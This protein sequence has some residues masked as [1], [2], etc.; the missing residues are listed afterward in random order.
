MQGKGLITLVAVVLGL[1]CLNELL[2]TWYASKIENQATQIAG[3]D[4]VKYQKEM[5]RLSKDTLNLGFTKLYYSRAKEREMKLG[6]DLKGGI[7]ALLE[8]NQRDLINDLTN[9]STNPILLETLDQTDKVQKNSTKSYIENFFVVF[10]EVNKAKGANLKLA[11]PEIFGNTN[12]GEIKFNSTDE[13]VKNIVRRKISASEGSA[14]EVIRT[15][16]DKMGVTQPN[17]QR[18]PGTGR[19]SVEM[20]GIKDVDRVKK[21]LST[22]AKLQFWE[23]QQPQEILPYFEQLNTV[24][25]AKGDS[26]GVAKGTN[27]INLLQ[28]STL[29]SNGVGNIKLSDTAAVNKI[30]NSTIA[31]KIRPANVK[32]TQFMWGYKPDANDQNNL[33]LYA[34][35][36]NINQKAP[37]D[38]A[39]ES[40]RVNYDEL[41]RVVVDMQMDSKGA[42]DWKTLTGKNVNKPVAVTLDNVVYTAPNVVNEIPNGRTQISGNF[43]QQEAQDL[44]D[45]LGAGKLPASAKV[46][47]M[48]VV[49]P[50]LGKASID[51]GMLS[52]FIAFIVLLSYIIFYYGGAGIYAVIAMVINLFYIFGIMDSVDATLT[53]PGIAGIVLSMAM[54]VDTNVII[55]ERTKEELFA[56]KHILEAYKDGF[57]HALSAIIDGHSTTILTAIVLYVFGTGPIKGFAVTLII[58]ILMTFFT[59]VLLSRVMIFQRLNKGKHLSVWTP[60]TKN[61]FRYTWIDFIGKRKFAYMISLFLTVASLISIAVNGFKYGIDFTGGRNYVV[62]FDKPV[63]VDKVENGLIKLFA[64]EDGKNSAVEAKTIG[65]GNQL[66]IS[67]DYLIDDESLKADQTIEE[68]LFQGLKQYLPANMTLQEFKQADKDHAGIIS[69]AK[70]G[71]T[72]ADDIKTHGTLAVIAA[73]GG[74]FIYILF[75]FSKWQFSLGAV[76]GL[77]HDAVIILGTYSL[78]HKYMPFNMEINQDFIAAILTVLGYSINDTVIVFDRIREYLREKKALTLAGLFD[79]SISSTLGRTFNTSFTTILVILAIFIFGGDNLRGFMFA[80]LIGIGFGTYSSIFISSAIAYDCLKEKGKEDHVHVKGRTT[81]DRE[82]TDKKKKA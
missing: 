19:I 2:P 75:R 69:S 13:Q 53:L 80:L 32:Y 61:L 17:V 18:V 15:R 48:D 79:D 25:A 10:D 44:V 60:P 58:G 21:M 55:Y 28:L 64:T 45:V 5:E 46:V 11:D 76:A 70:V 34:I 36:G 50:S 27:L 7:N 56:G 49:G 74:I 8:I 82:T 14:Y 24:I 33:V 20:P 40:A 59:S 1:I 65:T 29:R 3:T 62:K 37:V 77:F 68:K 41:G 31:K 23:V 4:P 63:D 26:I 43:S 66:K 35:R 30:L 81:T 54:A 9:Y 72:V 39:V 51:A 52:F 12:L 73:L 78:L 67:T 57:K 38:G 42:K 71:P 16:I 47:Q 22:S 6:L